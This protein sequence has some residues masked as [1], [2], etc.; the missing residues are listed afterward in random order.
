MRRLTIFSLLWLGCA[1]LCAATSSVI[2]EEPASPEQL[3]ADAIRAGQTQ[4]RAAMTALMEQLRHESPM[5]RQSSAWALGQFGASVSEAVS[6]LMHALGDS[7]V[8]VRWAAATTLG[9][10]GR[11]AQSAESALWQATLDRDIDVR[12]AALMALRTVSTAKSNEATSALS[13]CLQCSVADVQGEAIAT[14]SAIHSRWND[15]EKRALAAQLGTVLSG[16]NDDHRLAVAVLL[17]DFGLSTAEAISVL[18]SATDDLDEH[19]QTAALQAVERFADEVDRR[20]NQLDSKQRTDLRQSCEVAAKIL[21]NRDGGSAGVVRIAGQFERLNDGIQLISAEKAV[22]LQKPIH[23]AVKTEL[24]PPVDSPSKVTKA[25]PSIWRWTFPLL[26]AG[27]GLWGLRQGLS[28]RS[29]AT[30]STANDGQAESALSE[31]SSVAKI[32]VE[33]IAARREAINSLSDLAL[34]AAATLN[35]AMSDADSV[36]RWR[37]ASAV[38]AV[39]SA[40]VPQL[41]AAVTSEDPEVRRLAITS[42]RGLGA[43]AVSPFVQALQDNDARM[44]QAAAVTLGQIGL[45]A[46]DTVPQ[47]VTALS[48]TDSRVRAAAAFSL[49]T[50]GA[51]AMEAVPALRAALSDEFA[52]VRARAAFALGQIGPSARRTAEELIWLVSDPD[53]SVRRNAVSALGGIGADTAVVL[54]ALRQAMNDE[55]DG[56]HRCAATSLAV[57][58]RGAVAAEAQR[59]SERASIEHGV[60]KRPHETPL[61]TSSSSVEV[62]SKSLADPSGPGLKVFDPEQLNLPEVASDTQSLLEAADLIE[63]LQDADADVRW[64]ASQGLEQLGVSAVPEMIA[65][66]NHRNPAVRRLLLLALGRVGT[67]ARAAMPAMLVALHD[68]NADVRCAAADG[69]GQLGVVSRSMVQALVQALSDPNAEVRRYAATTLG[70]F[71]QQ[72]REATTALQIASI[73][74]MT[75]KVRSAAQTALQR[76]SESLVGAA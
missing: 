27:I 12:C 30:D 16:K 65:S 24:L 56:V 38:T 55:D 61:R 4:D 7:D 11:P 31:K 45:G 71:G 22:S 76:I 5:V 32:P 33:D 19:V 6:L 66:L 18:A 68:V 58:D 13:E 69:L 46:I 25:S 64:K 29:T 36:V 41:L 21:R 20:W 54:P 53:V 75:A 26:L 74:D 70:R 43:N 62:S 35:L 72:G 48:D 3:A 73:S 39:H 37:S 28:S 34:D 63:Q 50:F 59:S 40:T 44:R 51:H 42:L 52:S 9:R 67:E 17:G 1:I 15:S 49:S 47:L 57:I 10:I 60:V 14:L 2:A 23:S 8:R